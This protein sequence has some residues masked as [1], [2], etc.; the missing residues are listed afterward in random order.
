MI[1][2]KD[3]GEED[4]TQGFSMD[5][6]NP[7][8]D[9]DEDGKGDMSDQVCMIYGV[10]ITINECYI[11]CSTLKGI[12]TPSFAVQILPSSKRMP[13]QHIHSAT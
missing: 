7:I 12:L 13:I 4:E 11:P 10:E 8:P 3:A 2:V 1:C 9:E 6:E 5:D